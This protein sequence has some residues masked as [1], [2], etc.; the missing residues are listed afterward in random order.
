MFA[1]IFYLIGVLFVIRTISSIKS[2]QSLHS[3]KEWRAIYLEKIGRVPKDSEYRDKKE[4]DL[5][6][7]NLALNM[8]EIIWL[9]IG[10][11]TTNIYIFLSIIFMF[12][13]ISRIQKSFAFTVFEKSLSMIFI[14]SR[15]SLYL[16]L[17]V[18]HFTYQY[19]LWSI[20][21]NWI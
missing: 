19:D 18:N 7:T 14:I 6:Q 17:I 11:F 5:Y 21:K 3:I 8:V 4:L 13:F 9:L 2:F 15:F 1:H 12:I 10:L 16:L 20:I